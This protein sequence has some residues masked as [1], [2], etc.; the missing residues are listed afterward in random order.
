VT[1]Q[2][3]TDL[4]ASAALIAVAADRARRCVE[5]DV[6]DGAAAPGSRARW[7]GR[8]DWRRVRVR[9]VQPRDNGLHGAGPDR[10]GVAVAANPAPQSR[11]LRD[12][13]RLCRGVRAAPCGE[14]QRAPRS[15]SEPERPPA[16]VR[17]NAR[18][19]P[20]PS[21]V[22]HA[23]S[24]TAVR[25]I[26][27]WSRPGLSMP[28]SCSMSWRSRGLCSRH[29]LPRTRAQRRHRS[30]SRYPGGTGGCRRMQIDVGGCGRSVPL[31]TQ[32]FRLC[33]RPAARHAGLPW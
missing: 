30:N 13:R 17:R 28:C 16:R 10:G 24:G 20:V 3:A 5:P 23:G 32:A 7:S 29:H 15:A 11:V 12:V 25:R 19:S 26:I 4:P 33:T 8:C 22:A 6:H 9:C 14:A 2:P 18:L 1:A 27:F 21:G 31:P